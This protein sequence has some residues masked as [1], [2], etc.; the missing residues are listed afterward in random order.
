MKA[1]MFAS[2]VVL[3]AATVLSGCANGDGQGFGTVS[4]TM[5][6]SLEGEE[7]QAP[8]GGVG[9]LKSFTIGIGAVRLEAITEVEGG[10][11][12]QS[13]LLPIGSHW[14][15]LAG[16]AQ[17]PY[18]PLEVDQGDYQILSVL[19]TR[20]AT[21]IEVDGEEQ[22]TEHVWPEGF[23]ISAEIDIPVNR[24]RPPNIGLTTELVVDASAF[25]NLD[26]SGDDAA[27]Q[28]AARITAT[29]NV[30]ATWIRKAD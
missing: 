13:T 17:I 11:N 2:V 16:F 23:A 7:F 27:A 15:P 24:D 28:L 4:G 12:R 6:V 21:T 22:S 8:G 29:S 19:V 1:L 9:V 14:A 18:G 10:E 5:A 3:S 20:I 30:N 26:L 25:D